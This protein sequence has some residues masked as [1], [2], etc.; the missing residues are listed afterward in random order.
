MCGV[1]YRSVSVQVDRQDRVEVDKNVSVCCA[2]TIN[3]SRYL[4]IESSEIS[5]V[6]QIL[7]CFT[8]VFQLVL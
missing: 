7:S 6:S 1:F 8:A 4:H 2:L 5:V 3:Y